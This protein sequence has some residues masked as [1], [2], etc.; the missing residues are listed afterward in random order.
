[1]SAPIVPVSEVAANLNPTLA[2]LLALR[3][4][5]LMLVPA[6]IVA[7]LYFWRYA[8]A[9]RTPEGRGRWPVWKPLLFGLG[10][11]LLL[12]TTQSRAAGLTSGSMALYMGRLMVLA[13]VVPPLLMLGIPRNVNL[14]PRRGLGRVLGVLLDPWVA[15]GVW[16]AVII[17]WNIPAGFNASVVTNTAAALLPALYLLSSL[18]VWA[19]VLRPLPAVQPAT[20]GSR[21]WFGLLAALPM[22]TVGM[23]WLY[24]PAVLYTPY[25][26]ALCLWNLTPLDNQQFSGWIMMLAGL[27]ALA[28]AFIQLFAWLIALADG[29]TQRE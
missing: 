1:M 2:D 20:I 11:V 8:Q 17:F 5:P 12:L 23:V 19:V 4:D 6:L 3:P 14:D 22:M 25:V 18:M 27:P 10:I 13:E 16:S 7:A 21:G 15:L 24:S 29:G 26:N 9:R 28:L